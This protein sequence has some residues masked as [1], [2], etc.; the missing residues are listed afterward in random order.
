[1]LKSFSGIYDL[2]IFRIT[3]A[4]WGV[5]DTLNLWYFELRIPLDPHGPH[6]GSHSDSREAHDELAQLRQ[7]LWQGP[8]PIPWLKHI[9]MHGHIVPK[10][11]IVSRI[12][13]QNS[14]SQVSSYWTCMNG[15]K[16]WTAWNNSVFLGCNFPSRLGAGSWGWTVKGWSGSWRNCR[17]DGF[18]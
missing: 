4:G 7:Q 13:K 9:P 1:M 5:D 18:I 17:L 11:C 12:Y 8:D 2:N 3:L 10:F 14:P 16:P 6:H 15:W